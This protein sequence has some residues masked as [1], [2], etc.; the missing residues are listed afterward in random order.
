MSGPDPERSV[1]RITLGDLM[2]LGDLA[3]VDQGHF[4]ERRPEYR[5]RLLCTAL[6]Q[7]A[8]LHYVHVSSGHPQPNGVKDFDVWTFFARIPGLRFPDKRHTHADFGPSRFGR[9]DSELKRFSHF[10]GRRVDLFMRD[11]AVPVDADPVAALRSY[12]CVPRTTSAKHLAAKAVVMI[13]PAERL[14]EVVW[15]ETN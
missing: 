14:G 7:G 1:E 3:R 6:C 5:D 10:T 15:P 9:W 4:F 12:L 2:H 8:G 11:L 13:V